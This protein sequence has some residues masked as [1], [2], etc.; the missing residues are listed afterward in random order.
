MKIAKSY[1]IPRK[2]KEE[3]P[4]TKDV[5]SLVPVEDEEIPTERLRSFTLKSIPAD[6]DSDKYKVTVRVIYGDED[7][8][9]IVNWYQEVQKVLTG[10]NAT[11][12]EAQYPL[13]KTMM[14]GNA[15]AQFD[16]ALEIL[17]KNRFTA[18]KAAALDDAARAGI[19]AA[20]WE[21]DNNKELSQI[22][23]AIRSTVTEI[24][25]PRVL[26]RIKRFMRRDCRKPSNM[27]AS[28]RT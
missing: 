13:V 28:E 11:T 10:L 8:R 25:P 17:R 14:A 24:M 9:A 26:A 3:K 12:W 5:I 7:V 22:L 2:S 19:E 21:H 16:M 4:V 20:G 27:K 23:A 1:T 18:R 6:A 15:T